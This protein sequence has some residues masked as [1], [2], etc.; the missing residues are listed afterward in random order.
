MV[1]ACDLLM[2]WQ[3]WPTCSNDGTKPSDA[4]QHSLVKRLAGDHMLMLLEPEKV[5]VNL[6]LIN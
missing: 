2:I 6:T 5:V 3:L 1:A 4:T